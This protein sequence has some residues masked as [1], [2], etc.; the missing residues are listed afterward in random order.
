MLCYRV[1]ADL[2]PTSAVST[3]PPAPTLVATSFRRTSAEPAACQ[4]STVAVQT[5]AHTHTYV[6]QQL[7]D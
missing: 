7:S 4:R 3:S 6:S 1:S 5:R 2:L